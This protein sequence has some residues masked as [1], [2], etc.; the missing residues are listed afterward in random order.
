MS[1]DKFVVRAAELTGAYGN[2]KTAP[3]LVDAETI[4]LARCTMVNHELQLFIH[5]CY[6]RSEQGRLI[7]L[8]SNSQIPKGVWA[9][10]G[11]SGKS[12]LTRTERDTLRRYLF[13]LN[14]R[15]PP[16]PLFFYSQ[17]H[18][19]V[20]TVIYPTVE[21]ALQWLDRYQM[22]PALWLDCVVVSA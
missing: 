6:K 12:G 3:E 2:F 15:R 18:W 13:S 8:R 4:A 17:R 19:H 14:T 9:P 21:E 11:S 20:N 7:N 10:W 5:F 16:R 1:L 22:T